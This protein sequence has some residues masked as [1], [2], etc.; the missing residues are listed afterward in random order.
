MKRFLVFL[1]LAGCATVPDVCPVIPEVV[2]PCPIPPEI[3]RPILPISQLK[4][5][6]L[7]GMNQDKK[8]ELLIQT[9]TTSLSILM[10]YAKDLEIIVNGY[11]EKKK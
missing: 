5:E 10:Q 1:L 4:P 8:Q 2:A 3:A 11:K 9:G 6:I 7:K